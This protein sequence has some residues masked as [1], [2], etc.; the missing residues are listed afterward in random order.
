MIEHNG[1]RGRIEY[2]PEDRIFHGRV[3]GLRDDSVSFEG[4]SVEE[5]EADFRAAVDDYLETCKK[6]GRKPERE[7]SGR[8]PL[9]IDPELHREVALHAE[10]DGS[11]VNGWIAGQLRNATG[12]QD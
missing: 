5:I 1:Y 8:I 12:T 10:V 7:Y 9:R 2:D 3:L 6:L 4:T 11:S